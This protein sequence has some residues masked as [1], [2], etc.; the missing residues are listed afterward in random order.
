MVP[1]LCLPQH[2]S[3]AMLDTTYRDPNQ[4]FASQ[5]DLQDSGINKLQGACKVINTVLHFLRNIFR[6]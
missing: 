6:I 4:V 2:P 3:S 1:T 5:M